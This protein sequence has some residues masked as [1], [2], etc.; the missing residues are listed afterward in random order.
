MRNKQEL[1]NNWLWSYYKEQGGKLNDPQ[2]FINHFYFEIERIDFNGQIFE[3]KTRRDLSKFFEDMDRKF[4]I[5]TLWDEEGEFIK[6][7]E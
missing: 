6:V 5:Q 7:V 2:E 4:N 1:D 3:Q